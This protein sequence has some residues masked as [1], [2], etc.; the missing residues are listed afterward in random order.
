MTR[1]QRDA[2][3]EI[4]E[5]ISRGKQSRDAA[6]AQEELARMIATMLREWK[7]KPDQDE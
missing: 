2:M 5:R 1:R 7:V 4:C 6:A 3:I